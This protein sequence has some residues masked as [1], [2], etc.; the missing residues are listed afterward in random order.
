MKKVFYAGM[1]LGVLAHWPSS[2]QAAELTVKL[3]PAATKISFTL[4]AVMH[5]VHGTA[6][7]KGGEVKFDPATGAASG[8][9][10][11]DATSAETGSEGRDK[12]M[13]EKVLESAKFPEI[14][15]ELERVEGGFLAQGVSNPTLKGKLTI[16]GASH[17]VSIPARVEVSGG[18][19]KATLTFKVPYVAWGM[20]D[21]SGFVLRVGKEV[22]VT[23]DAVGSLAP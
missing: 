23:V 14:S 2:A 6:K 9:F 18:T 22:P 21:P 7:A 12:D 15:F 3:D 4:D 8:R 16:H 11:A 20:T 5:T 17:A 19:I 13:H 10:V 1:V